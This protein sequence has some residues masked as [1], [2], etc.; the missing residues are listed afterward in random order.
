LPG[1]KQGPKQD[2]SIFSALS[3]WVGGS[4]VWSPGFS[5][6]SVSFFYGVENF[7]DRRICAHPAA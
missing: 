4:E 7:Q 3:E 2:A 5:R 6:W 1:N